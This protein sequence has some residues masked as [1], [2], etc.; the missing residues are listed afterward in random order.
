MRLRVDPIT[1]SSGCHSFLI[2]TAPDSKR[3]ISRRLFTRRVR[4]AICRPQKYAPWY[5]T[6]TGSVGAPHTCTD[7]YPEVAREAHIEG[8]TTLLFHI[9]T[10]GSVGDMS[11]ANS[12]G[13]GDL[14][15]AAEACALNW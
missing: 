4:R 9:K 11:I 5:S 1:S 6:S 15:N 12:S 2:E 14:D 3:I 10:D 8:T 7:A 13:N